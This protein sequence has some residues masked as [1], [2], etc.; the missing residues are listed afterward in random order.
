MRAMDVEH[1]AAV[2][3][4]AA[5]ATRSE[6]AA[7]FARRARRT[8]PDVDG[9]DARA[10]QET[11]EARDTLLRVTSPAGRQPPPASASPIMRPR[12]Q[13]PRLLAVWAGLLVIAAFLAIYAVDHPVHPV[14]A[15]VR[16]T[17]LGA[18]A[19][20]FGATG[21]RAFLVAALVLIAITV[22]LTLVATSLGGLLALLLLVPAMYGLGLA[23]LA[24]RR[25]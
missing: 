19:V 8:H 4:V 7:A 25:R 2:L 5:G 16:W 22:A 14:E 24:R 18:S 21:R 11:V 9:G 10:F 15:V 23:G 17:L 1:A 20:A 12:I 6:I 13:G 3:G